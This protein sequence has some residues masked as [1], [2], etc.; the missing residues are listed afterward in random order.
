MKELRSD[1]TIS[2]ATAKALKLLHQTQ[3]RN[4]QLNQ[5]NICVVCDCCIIGTEPVK[6]LNQKLLRHHN[7]KQEVWSQNLHG[8]LQTEGLL[9]RSVQLL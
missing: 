9:K 5:A 4:T 2:K 3:I 7:K 8:L 6:R 1:E